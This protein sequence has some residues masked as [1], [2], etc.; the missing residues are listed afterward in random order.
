MFLQVYVFQ[1]PILFLDTFIGKWQLPCI[2]GGLIT[3]THSIILLY[4][5]IHAL[6]RVHTSSQEENRN[7][8]IYTEFTV[9]VA[10]FPEMGLWEHFIGLGIC[11]FV[12]ILGFNGRSGGAYRYFV[13]CSTIN[14]AFLK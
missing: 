4:Y 10:I 9:K 6:L 8:N 7:W 1:F 11:V 14:I 2:P 13:N 5:N 12:W 3:G